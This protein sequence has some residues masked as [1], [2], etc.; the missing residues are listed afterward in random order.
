[1]GHGVSEPKGLLGGCG[2]SWLPFSCQPLSVSGCAL[3]H[4]SCPPHLAPAVTHST[5]Q[6]GKWWPDPRWPDGSGFL[7]ATTDFPGHGPLTDGLRWLRAL[8]GPRQP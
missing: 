6:P 2:Q 1:M 3:A 4:Y 7:R 8:W 5:A